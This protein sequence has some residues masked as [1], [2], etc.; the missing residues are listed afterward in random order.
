M[1]FISRFEAKLWHNLTLRYE[2]EARAREDAAVQSQP[3]VDD[4]AAAAH[5]VTDALNTDFEFG[6]GASVASET[7]PSESA[8]RPSSAIMGPSVAMEAYQNTRGS[9][10][11]IRGAMDEMQSMQTNSERIS[12]QQRVLHDVTAALEAAGK[13]GATMVDLS[14][15]PMRDGGS[16]LDALTVAGLGT[17]TAITADGKSSPDALAKLAESLTDAQSGISS[18]NQL[19]LLALQDLMHQ[20]DLSIQ[21]AT[22]VLAAASAL[23]K[24]IAGN[25][26]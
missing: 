10:E 20:R 12:G 3:L 22:N 2:S 14:L 1:T 15:L 4:T 19:R 9:N 5:G 11:R 16:L 17:A 24:Q 7:T 21:F 18:G 26:R 6:S 23:D 13:R 25:I 8:S